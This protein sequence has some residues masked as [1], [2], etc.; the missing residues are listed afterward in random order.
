[1]SSAAD[2]AAKGVQ[3]SLQAYT[4]E[5]RAPISQACASPGI[6]LQSPGKS[7][8]QPFLANGLYVRCMPPH[9]LVSA[10]M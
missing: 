3:P 5:S 7:P 10:L 8:V 9:E 4:P 1:M 2:G 6:S